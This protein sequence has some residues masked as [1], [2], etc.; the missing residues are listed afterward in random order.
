[1][2]H[3]QDINVLE[4]SIET[5]LID[6]DLLVKYKSPEKAFDL[7]RKTIERHPHTVSLREK[8]REIAKMHM[9]LG[10]ASE[11]CAAL[12][13]L[14]ITHGQ[15]D[16]AYDRLLEAKSLDP[17]VSIS[18]GLEAIR[19]ARQKTETH[20]ARSID[21]PKEGVTLAGNIAVMDIFDT[22]QTIENARTTGLLVIKSDMQTA[23]IAFNLGKIVDARAEGVDSIAAFRKIIEIKE[24]N[25]EFCV[26]EEK[27]P[28]V[29]TVTSNKVFLLNTLASLE[30]EKA[31]HAGLRDLSKE[32]IGY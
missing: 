15:F 30:A 19:R 12:A 21:E 27:F 28:E 5:I 11:Q 29:I 32:E 18:S 10:E 9:N 16:L 25:F 4:D 3:E 8:M 17:R 1:V 23:S 6:A 22:V 14:Y 26:S 2:L 24:G 13:G 7:L 31:E 20:I